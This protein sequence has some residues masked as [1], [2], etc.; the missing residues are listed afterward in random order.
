MVSTVTTRNDESTEGLDGPTL[1]ATIAVRPDEE[2][3]CVI[4]E[5]HTDGGVLEQHL[6][7]DRHGSDP[8]GEDGT[9]NT[10]VVDR[11]DERHDQYVQSDIDE[12]CFCLEFHEVECIPTF[13]R[14]QDHRIVISVLVPDRETLRELVGRLRANGAT[15]SVYGI[16]RSSAHADGSL[17]IDAADV[18]D[19]QLEALEAAVETGYYET[20]RGADLEVLADRLD[21]SK[22]AV[23]QR[24]KAVESKLAR[25]LVEQWSGQP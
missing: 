22:S 3:G 19:K 10:T 12:R 15:V 17:V 16:T 14:I 11:D 8:A 20:P 13:E 21:V 4:I 7:F 24:L 1:Q 5:G 6:T 18:T 9:C 2:A 25:K 23:S